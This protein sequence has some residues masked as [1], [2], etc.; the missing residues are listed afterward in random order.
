MIRA[1]SKTRNPVEELAT[2]VA[3]AN[4]QEIVTSSSARDLMALSTRIMQGTTNEFEEAFVQR[5]IREAEARGADYFEELGRKVVVSGEEGIEQV[6]NPDLINQLR[7]TA[8]QKGWV[9]P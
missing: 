9:T 7:Q 1:A 8:I 5:A 6:L 2:A 3:R 4:N